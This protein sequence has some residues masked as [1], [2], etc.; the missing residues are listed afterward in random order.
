MGLILLI[1]NSLYSGAK[2][3]F[4][5]E[6][7]YLCVD[8]KEHKVKRK[9][10]ILLVALLSFILL[11]MTACRRYEQVKVV[12]GEVQS[13]SMNGF[14]AMDVSLMIGIDNPAGKIVVQKAEG[15]LKHFGK[16]IGKVTLAP[17][18]LLP[19]SSVVYPVQAHVELSAGLG[20]KDLLALADPK[21][22]EELAVDISFSGR[23]SGVVL[24]KQFNDIPLKQLLENN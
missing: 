15:T 3:G 1:Y 21:R 18:T 2:I 9:G 4:F 13:V 8:I 11:S 5:G 12:S 16:V 20:F 14:K 24:K 7:M 6:Y 19:R 22:Y 17:L 23:A 10:S